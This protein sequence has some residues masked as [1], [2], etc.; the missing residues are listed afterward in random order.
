MLPVVAGARRTREQIVLYTVLLV[1][2]TVLALLGG[3]FGFVYAGGAGILD[4]G[5]L[6]Q[7]VVAV[8]SGSARSARR[9]YYYSIVYLALVFAV[10]AADRVVGGLR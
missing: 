3:S 1:V 10:M 4:A 7:S 8:R 9:L 5:L 2:V 6:A